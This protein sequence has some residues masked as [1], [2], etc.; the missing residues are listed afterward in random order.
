MAT[1][2][3]RLRTVSMFKDVLGFDKIADSKDW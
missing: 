2:Q 1:A 3:K